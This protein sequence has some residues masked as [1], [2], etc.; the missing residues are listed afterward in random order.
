[1][2]FGWTLAE[3]IWYETEDFMF[4]RTEDISNDKRIELPSSSGRGKHGTFFQ[5]VR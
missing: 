3:I 5:P 1:M 2:L 4:S